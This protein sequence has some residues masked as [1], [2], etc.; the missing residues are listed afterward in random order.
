M[1]GQQDSLQIHYQ[2]EKMVSVAS[3]S[4]NEGL[5]AGLPALMEGIAQEARVD[6]SELKVILVGDET[7]LDVKPSRLSDSSITRLSGIISRLTSF[8]IRNLMLRS[9]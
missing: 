2:P 1:T 4:A 6:L 3:S 9:A 8:I 5:T 7:Q